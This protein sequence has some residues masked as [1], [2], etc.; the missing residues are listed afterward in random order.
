M[1]QND[2]SLDGVE[3]RGRRERMEREMRTRWEGGDAGESCLDSLHPQQREQWGQDPSGTVK[4]RNSQGTKHV[5]SERRARVTVPQRCA[6]WSGRN[7][8]KSVTL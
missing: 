6:E 1:L 4:T 3:Q 7:T 5:G 2:S 8:I